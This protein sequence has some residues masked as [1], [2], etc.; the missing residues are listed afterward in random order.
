MPVTTSSITM[1][2]RSTRKS[3]TD[4]DCAALNPGEVVL[5][6]GRVEIAISKM[7]FSTQRKERITL[8]T[9]TVLTRLLENRRPKT[10]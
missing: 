10:R 7:T 1:V 6:V 2:N 4:V 5:Q 3:Q 9:A 8:P